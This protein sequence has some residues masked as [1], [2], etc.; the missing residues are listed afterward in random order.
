MVGANT[1]HP[2]V[3]ISATSRMWSWE[4][5]Y[6]IDGRRVVSRDLL[7]VP[8]GLPVKIGTTS[9]DVIHSF[10]V[11]RLGG[12]IDSIPGQVNTITL[13]ADIEGIECWPMSVE[14]SL[15]IRMERV[16]QA[17]CAAAHNEHYLGFTYTE[18][19]VTRYNLVMRQLRL[20]KAQGGVHGAVAVPAP[21]RPRGDLN[22]QLLLIDAEAWASAVRTARAGGERGEEGGHGGG[23]GR[24]SAAGRSWPPAA[25]AAGGGGWHWLAVAAACVR[26]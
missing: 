24:W 4:F 5:V 19:Y 26:A 7:H 16:F 1:P 13:L 14:E 12:K 21:S 17:T 20:E 23:G 2:A 22:A 11:P 6:E 9:V 3:T 18:P 8:V 25:V 15:Q 10:W